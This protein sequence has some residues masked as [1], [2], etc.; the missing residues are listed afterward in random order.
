MLTITTNRTTARTQGDLAALQ[1]AV[2]NAAAAQAILAPYTWLYEQRED[3]AA[4]MR[5]ANAKIGGWCLVLTLTG[6]CKTQDTT[7]GLLLDNVGLVVAIGENVSF[8]RGPTGSKIPVTLMLERVARTLH[9]SQI[10][11]NHVILFQDFA[12]VT[13]PERGVL[14]YNARF[15]TSAFLSSTGD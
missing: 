6:S 9:G 10:D 5:T 11:S 12:L 7:E 14:V 8:N 4:A 3:V 13:A 2:C 15:A 1:Q